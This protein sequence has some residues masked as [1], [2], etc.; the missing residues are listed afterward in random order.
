[1][2]LSNIRDRLGQAYGAQHRFE[3]I[4][5][6]EG[7]FAVLIEI[8]AEFRETVQNGFEAHRQP[9]LASR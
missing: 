2:G 1:V 6:V 9:V 7:G 3:T 8:P 5:P 4:E